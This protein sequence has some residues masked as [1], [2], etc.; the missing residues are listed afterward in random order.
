MKSKQI[1]G[2]QIMVGKLPFF[3]I[4]PRIYHLYKTNMP[5][6]FSHWLSQQVEDKEQLAVSHR[7]DFSAL[8]QQL[9]HVEIAIFVGD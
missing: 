4:E 1:C 3:L 9:G 2:L 5:K 7:Y 6:V 8:E